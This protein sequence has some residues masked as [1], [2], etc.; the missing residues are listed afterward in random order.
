MKDV[1]G[2]TLAGPVNTAFTTAGAPPLTI[3]SSAVGTLTDDTDSNHL[4]GSK[5]T[6]GSSPVTLTSLSVHVGTV[7]AAPNNQFQLAVY[8]DSSGSPGTLLVPTASGTLTPNAWNPVPVSFTLAANTTYW[9]VYNS[10]GTGST[11]NNMHFS[12]GAAGSGAYSNAVVPF[13]TW[14]ATFG[15]AVKDT[16]VYSLYGA[17]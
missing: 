13:G 4:N 7:S 9:F 17:Y 2:N 10:N 3:G 16:L 6:T 12:T 11:V 1:A 14:P 15:P 8:S 5:V